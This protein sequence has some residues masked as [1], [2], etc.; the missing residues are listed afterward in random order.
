[1]GEGKTA[2]PALQRTQFFTGAEFED[3][4]DPNLTQVPD[5]LAPSQMPLR[6]DPA[7]TRTAQEKVVNSLANIASLHEGMR[8]KRSFI[9]EV[10]I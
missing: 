9:D 2:A 4:S 6:P 5:F 10:R 8:L 3:E 1:L 7:T